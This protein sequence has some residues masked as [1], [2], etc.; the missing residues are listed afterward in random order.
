MSYCVNCGVE[1]ADSERCCPLCATEVINPAKPAARV[2]EYPYPKRVETISRNI[3]KRF[4]VSMAGTIMLIPTI[5]TIFCDYITDGTISWSIYV[6][7]AM[8]LLFTWIF[9]PMLFKKTTVWLNVTLGFISTAIYVGLICLVSG[10][11][12]FWTLGLPIVLA[13]GGLVVLLS[14]LFTIETTKGL[15]IRVA[16]VLFGIG[17][18]AIVIDLL[19]SLYIGIS[20]IPSW[21]GYVFVPCV[22]LGVLALILRKHKN[23]KDEI[24]RRFY[25]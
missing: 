12:W 3:D 10:G 18:L 23:F 9:V 13:L 8:L 2:H 14:V 15:L 22:L 16:F 5:I 4:L 21:S 20:L 24:R 7:G 1:L 11:D 25:V 6:A 19:I 17:L